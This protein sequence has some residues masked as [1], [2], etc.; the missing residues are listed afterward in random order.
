MR[1]LVG[2]YINGHPMRSVYSAENLFDA[3]LVKDALE[4]AGIPAFI[5]GSAL[6]GAVGELPAG[7][8]IAVQVPDSAWADAAPIAA[9]VDAWLSEKPVENGTDGLEPTPA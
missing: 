4:T 8:L 2:R 9:D 5:T 3:Q 7:G 1:Y 6:S